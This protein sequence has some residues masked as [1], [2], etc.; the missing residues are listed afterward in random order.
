[1]SWK[2]LRFQTSL[3]PKRDTDPSRAHR[4]IRFLQDHQRHRSTDKEGHSSFEI[5]CRAVIGIFAKGGIP[6]M[7]IR[8]CSPESINW[9]SDQGKEFAVSINHGFVHLVDLGRLLHDTC[10]DEWFPKLSHWPLV[11]E[12]MMDDGGHL[13]STRVRRQKARARVYL[14][15][16]ENDGKVSCSLKFVILTYLNWISDKTT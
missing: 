6:G 8:P 15:T 3:V 16:I 12:A 7:F 5:G 2:L 9:I 10:R 14:L 11:F 13:S 1:M 4:P